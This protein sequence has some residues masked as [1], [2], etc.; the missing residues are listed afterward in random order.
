V[1]SIKHPCEKKERSLTRD[2]RVFAW[3][4]N[5]T[6][7]GAWK[8]KKRRLHKKERRVA[9]VVLK[10]LDSGNAEDGA[11]PKRAIP[12]KLRKSG[13]VSL[14]RALGIRKNDPGKRFSMFGYWDRQAASM[15]GR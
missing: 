8:R 12:R 14:G 4:G 5:K 6:F 9:G 15:E 2:H 11:S 10:K 1:S 3:E 7:R 13:V